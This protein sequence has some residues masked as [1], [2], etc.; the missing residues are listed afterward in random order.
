MLDPR[1]VVYSKCHLTI[2]GPHYACIHCDSKDFKVNNLT[3]FSKS[4]I[5]GGV[6]GE[7]EDDYRA[8]NSVD[9]P[10]NYP[11]PAEEDVL[12]SLLI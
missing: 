4:L 1:E 10:A 2:H 5:N 12:Y 3:I 9:H 8:D 11:W 6:G 7:E